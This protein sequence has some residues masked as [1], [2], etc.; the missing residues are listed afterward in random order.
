[1]TINEENFGKDDKIYHHIGDKLLVE[2]YKNVITPKEEKNEA[3]LKEG[4]TEDCLGI[5]EAQLEKILSYHL[6]KEENLDEW[7]GK[8]KAQLKK[9]LPDYLLEKHLSEVFLD[10]DVAQ[11]CKEILIEIEEK[12]RKG[13]KRLHILTSHHKHDPLT[14]K[15]VISEQTRV[16]VYI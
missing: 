12:K 9:N 1:M 14:L 3:S 11:L 7:L 2:Y 8:N 15:F 4:N 13:E 5:N 16:T 10:P 6:L